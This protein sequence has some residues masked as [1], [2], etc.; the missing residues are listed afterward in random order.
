MVILVNTPIQLAAK[1]LAF[2][3]IDDYVVLADAGLPA[4]SIAQ[5]QIT[6]RDG[7]TF[8][9]SANADTDAVGTVDVTV[10]VSYCT[11]C[12]GVVPTNPNAPN[13]RNYRV[14]A[15]IQPPPAAP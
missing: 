6:T 5:Q 12:G 4:D 10:T 15:T 3:I 1:E 8:L 11:S 13:V 9:V 7:R 2:E 14:V